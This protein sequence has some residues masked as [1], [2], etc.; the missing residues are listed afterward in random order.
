MDTKIYLILA[1]IIIAS[2][3]SEEQ[4]SDYN[5][6]VSIKNPDIADSTLRPNQKSVLNMKIINRNKGDTEINQENVSLYNSGAIEVIDGSKDCTPSTIGS[7][8]KDLVPKMSCEWKLKAPEKD[9]VKGFESKESSIQIGVEY[10]SSLGNSKAIKMDFQKVED[11]QESSGKTREISNEDIKTKIS[12]DNPMTL[13]SGSIEIESQNIGSGEV[14]G[15]GNGLSGGTLGYK[16]SPEI[17]ECSKNT[18]RLIEGRT[19]FFCDV[20]VETRGSR[21][22]FFSTSY[23]YRKTKTIGIEVVNN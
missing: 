11:I 17:I 19:S 5:A 2:G 3:C 12:Y 1:I 8:T 22:L 10:E 23:K 21:N 15:S 16:F 14:L 20:D 9:Y 13:N 7:V 4:K 18:Q 6:G